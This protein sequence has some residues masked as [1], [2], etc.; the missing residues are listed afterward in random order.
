MF[1]WVKSESKFTVLFILSVISIIVPSL[2]SH[3]TYFNTAF[4]IIFSVL[5]LAG[6]QAVSLTPRHKKLALLF[7][8]G[9]LTFSWL[10][11]YDIS[12]PIPRILSH[13]PFLFFF[14]YIVYFLVYSILKSQNVTPDVIFGAITGYIFMGYTGGIYFLVINDFYPNSFQHVNNSLDP[15]YFSFVTMTTLGYGD[16][17]PISNAA[18]GGVILL[19]IFGQFYIAV[20]VALLVSKY[21]NNKPEVGN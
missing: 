5:V 4:M 19:T 7:G 13:I 11:F 12:A 3:E 6:A 9:T 1:K 21:L 20:I 2:I 8:L 18:Q 17:T 15:V 14:A 16:I 10:L